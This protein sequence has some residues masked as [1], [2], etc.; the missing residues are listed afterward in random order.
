MP[1]YML[2]SAYADEGYE[3]RTDVEICSETVDLDQFAVWLA[4]LRS[5]KLEEVE[6]ARDYCVQR[7][8]DEQHNPY[9]RINLDA[10]HYQDMVVYDKREADIMEEYGEKYLER[11]RTAR[12]GDRIRGPHPDCG[13]S[14]AMTMMI[15]VPDDWPLGPARDESIWC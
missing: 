10:M 15:A 7:Y 12:V 8:E 11:L 9:R 4:G 5:H 6:K 2:I 3:G 13:R 1:R 14:M